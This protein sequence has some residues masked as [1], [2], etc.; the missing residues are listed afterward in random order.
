MSTVKYKK[1][2]NNN[3]KKKNALKKILLSQ[4]RFYISYYIHNIKFI[5]KIN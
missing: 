4:L 5:F 1:I 2:N 3:K